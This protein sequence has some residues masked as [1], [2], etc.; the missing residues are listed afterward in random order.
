[1]RI[2]FIL[3]FLFALNSSAQDLS[4]AVYKS[5]TLPSKLWN[6]FLS[7]VGALKSSAELSLP[8]T[9]KMSLTKTQEEFRKRYLYGSKAEAETNLEAHLFFEE[10]G[11]F[12]RSFEVELDL[13][14]SSILVKHS[15]PKELMFRG[16][17]QV[18]RKKNG[19]REVFLEGA[20]ESGLVTFLPQPFYQKLGERGALGVMFCPRRYDKNRNEYEVGALE[21]SRYRL[22]EVKFIGAANASGG[23]N[24]AGYKSYARAS[25]HTTRLISP[26]DV[27]EDV[28]RA[29]DPHV[30]ILYRAIPRKVPF[31]DH[32]LSASILSQVE[33]RIPAGFRRIDGASTTLE[34]REIEYKKPTSV[35]VEGN[36]IPV[37]PGVCYAILRE[38]KTYQTYDQVIAEPEIEGPSEPLS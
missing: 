1:M 38:G 5:D 36:S 31:T 23:I 37:N 4:H 7:Q 9:F 33:I 30:S 19:F 29:G 8:E 14:Y 26:A 24:T 13:S 25:V 18:A 34:V 22:K 6:Y 15:N 2:L 32:F 3:T 12:P 28:S 11:E 16:G 21:L 17:F 35:I 10:D 20:D 27:F